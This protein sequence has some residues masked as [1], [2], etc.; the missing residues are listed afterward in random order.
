[1]FATSN[2]TPFA[3]HVGGSKYWRVTR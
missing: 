1:L 3:R 2:L